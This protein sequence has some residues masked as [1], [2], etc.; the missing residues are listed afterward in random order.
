MEKHGSIFLLVWLMVAISFDAQSPNDCVNAIQVCGNQDISLDVSGVGNN[1]NEIGPNA[2]SSNEHNS[3]WIRITIKTGGTLGFTLTPASSAITEDYDFWVF[4]PTDNCSNL[5]TSIRCSTTNP[6]A[7]SQGNNLTGMNASSTEVSEGPGS[8]GDSF[9]RWLNVDADE[10]YYLILDRPIGQS[11]F[12]LTWTGTAVI[13]NP[14]EELDDPFGEFP[15]IEIC[16]GDGNGTEPFDFGSLSSDFLQGNSEFFIQYFSNQDNANIGFNPLSGTSNISDGTYYARIEN[17]ETACFELRTIVV[18]F[19]SLEVSPEEIIICDSDANGEESFDLNSIDY[20]VIPMGSYDLSFFESLSDA[21]NNQNE[22]GS[23]VLVQNNVENYYVRA[24]SGSH[25]CTDVAMV[26]IKM[27]Q[28]IETQDHFEYVC[29][30]DFDGKIVLTLSN[31]VSQLHLSNN[32]DQV[33][34]YPSISDAE[35]QTQALGSTYEFDTDETIYA[36][37]SNPG[38][39]AIASLRIQVLPIPDLGEDET[40]YF[41]PEQAPIHLVVPLGLGEYQWS[42]DA[43]EQSSETWVTEPG[44]YT[45]TAL[46]SNG[47]SHEKSFNLVHYDYPSITFVHEEGN[48][49]NIEAEGINS[50]LYFSIDQGQTWQIASVF[51]DLE[52]GVYEVLVKYEEGCISEPFIFVMLE[53]PNTFSPNGDG[54]NDFW[55][56]PHLEMMEGSHI[57]I[58]DRYGKILYDE[59]VL[60]PFRWDGFFAGRALPSTTYWFT[61]D[62]KLQQSRQGWIM[63]KNR[64]ND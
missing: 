54:I 49:I 61:L 32:F 44:V 64:N 15:N 47:C 56:I 3:L 11:A 21:E 29:D 60:S 38:C 4:G 20:Q 35:N 43:N 25:E 6:A 40:I 52:G 23:N 28:P 19:V 53:I 1:A 27:Y 48:T 59:D 51:T 9:V 58:Y 31:F 45:V 36:R 18:D 63:I 42:H 24:S 7:A 46:V 57:T 30:D 62:L 14:F 16:D 26:E 37:F 12:S 22:I 34:F 33:V 10:T 5:G 50:P 13:K 17:I 41:C 55:N 8:N 2:C 39:Y